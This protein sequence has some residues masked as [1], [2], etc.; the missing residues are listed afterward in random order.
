MLQA[1]ACGLVGDIYE[2]RRIIADSIEMKAYSPKDKE[3]YDKAYDKY[4]K[5]TNQ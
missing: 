3:A 5:I 1:K 2:M 4:L